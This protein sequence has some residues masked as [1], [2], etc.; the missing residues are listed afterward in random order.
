[1]ITL[2]SSRISSMANVDSRLLQA[3][4]YRREGTWTYSKHSTTISLLMP[5]AK[6]LGYPP[7]WGD[8][9]NL[10]S[11]GGS[12]AIIKWKELGLKGRDY[13]GGLPCEIIHGRIGKPFGHIGRNCLTNAAVR[14]CVGF[15]EALLI[16]CPVTYCASKVQRR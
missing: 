10:P 9:S 3:L 13:L 7:S 1:M 4:R 15:M 11:R 16:Y 12:G 14:G 2:T 6:E 8:P 5:M